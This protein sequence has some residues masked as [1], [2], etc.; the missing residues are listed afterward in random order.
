MPFYLVRNDITKMDTDAVVNAANESLLGGGGVDGAIHRAA[1]PELLEACR[2]L[3]G[4][5]EGDAKIT[6]G[7]ALKAKYIIHTVGPIWE[8]GGNGEEAVLRSC[9]RRSLSLAL[10]HGCASVAFPLISAGAYGYPKAEALETASSE[11][12]AFLEEHEMDVYLVLFGETE[13]LEAKKLFRDV[14]EYIDSIYAARHTDHNVEAQRKRLWHSDRTAARQYDIDLGSAPLPPEEG[15]LYGASLP[16]EEGPLYSAPHQESAHAPQDRE[17]A[18][19][20]EEA[21]RKTPRRARPKASLPDISPDWDRILRDTDEGFSQRLLRLI[22]QRGLTDAACY[23]RANVDRKLFSK[24]RSN[25]AY[26]PGKPTVFAFAVALE[27]SLDE[28]K[29]LLN[30]AGFALSR[31]SRFDIILE[32]FIRNGIYDIFQ[33]NEVLFRYDMP[34]LGSGM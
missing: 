19:P 32:Y 16:P 10:E 34:L 4:C 25:P 23:K 27:L 20:P 11:I 31:A 15:A 7:Y 9:Y 6:K 5:T 17:T 28:T 26:R 22:D 13:F 24:I 2:T 21:L 18:L 30:R 3:G 33:I 29:D 12:R 8:G 14:R 1:G